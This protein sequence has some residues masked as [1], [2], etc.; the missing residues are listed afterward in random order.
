MLAGPLLTLIALTAGPALSPAARLDAG[1][2]G[3]RPGPERAVWAAGALLGT[4]YVLHPLGDAAGPEVGSRFRLDAFDCVTFV[5]TAIALGSASR[6]AEAARLMDDIRYDGPP[7][8]ANRS[9]Y[10]EAQ[11][12]PANL[13]KGWIAEA[14]VAIAGELAQPIEEEV[15]AESWRRAQRAGLRFPELPENRRPM[16]RFRIAMVPVDRLARIADRIPA[17]TIALVVRAERP[18]RP[19]RVSHL[20]IVVVTPDGQ[21]LVRHATDAKGKRVV[22]EPFD[23]FVARS[24]R[25]FPRWPL[26]GLAFYAIQDN[27]ERARE[28]LRGPERPAEHLDQAPRARR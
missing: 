20:G 15:S 17:G 24:G 5:E 1:L 6:V 19:Y 4:P 3:Q 27:T 9:H 23:R 2:N 18:W 7:E 25:A 21:R 13:R 12:I 11:W 28:L 8:W 14:T 10:V 16:G 26:S 22:D